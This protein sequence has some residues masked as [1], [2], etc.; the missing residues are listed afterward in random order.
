MI[1]RKGVSGGMGSML[2][3][4]DQGCHL[5]NGSGRGGIFDPCCQVHDGSCRGGTGVASRMLRTTLMGCCGTGQTLGPAYESRVRRP[6]KSCI[7]KYQGGLPPTTLMPALP[8]LSNRHC[9]HR[10]A[11][12]DAACFP[13]RRTHPRQARALL[14][15]D[16]QPGGHKHRP[17]P[18]PDSSQNNM[19]HSSFC[20]P[21]DLQGENLGTRAPLQPRH[22]ILDHSRCRGPVKEV[23]IQGTLPWHGG[24]LGQERGVAFRDVL[25]Q[26]VP[27]RGSACTRACVLVYVHVIARVCGHV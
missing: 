5:H 9:V 23:V 22:P 15:G 8:A 7:K 19:H 10:A 11:T 3:S 17:R 20:A 14:T 13:D 2:T 27:V 4:F 21:L 6:L 24:I 26:G 1:F 16:E 18:W 25:R 12:T